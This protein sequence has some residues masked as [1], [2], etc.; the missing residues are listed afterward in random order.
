MP[1][2]AGKKHKDFTK[3]AFKA[4]LKELVERGCTAYVPT[5]SFADGMLTCG[6]DSGPNIDLHDPRSLDAVKTAYGFCRN[7]RACNGC[8]LDDGTDFWE[9]T[10]V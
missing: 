5:W 3:S 7:A 9:K 8:P 2:K 4:L 1:K 10:S 6:N